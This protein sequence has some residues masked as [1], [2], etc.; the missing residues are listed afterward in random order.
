MLIKNFVT[1]ALLSLTAFTFTPGA[2]RSAEAAKVK[3][4]KVVHKCTKRDTKENLLACA[5][6][7]ESRN[8]GKKGMLA[9]GNVVINR[10][11]D[12]AFPKTV[13]GVLFQ[14]GQF[15]YTYRGTFNVREK[16]SWEQAK[17][18]AHKLLYLNSN[19]PEARD[20]TDVTRGATYFK[21][22]SIR[23]HWEKD[24]NLVYRY[25]EHQFYR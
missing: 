20:A 15:S 21:R 14:R 22:K 11:N 2:V 4:A 13:K 3:S 7:A 8:Q 12:P 1:I 24:M 17:M 16:E 23:T 5:I 25:K 19:F 9:V 10:M 6:Y 18:I